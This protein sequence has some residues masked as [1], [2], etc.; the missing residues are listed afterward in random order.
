MVSAAHPAPVRVSTAQQSRVARAAPFLLGLIFALAALRSLPGGNIIDP[1]AARHA[2]NGAMVRDLV[3]SGQIMHPVAFGKR[4]YSHYP[5]L[6]IPY[7]PPLFPAI[8]SVF[9]AIGGV[10][11]TVARL[12]VALAVGISAVL[13][14]GLIVA[15]Y[16]SRA[17]AFFSTFAF[18]SWHWPQW[19]ANDVMLEF[20]ALALLL[21]SLYFIRSPVDGPHLYIFAV[22]AGAAVWTKQNTLFLGLVPFACVFLHR[23]WQVLRRKTIW[24]ASAVFGAAVAAFTGVV[25]MFGWT[26][27][28]Q[29]SSGRSISSILM[30]NPA[31]YAKSLSQDAGIVGTALIF[32]AVIAATIQA[33]RGHREDV[34]FLA[35]MYSGAAFL[36]SLGMLD[37]RYLIFAAPPLVVISFRSLQ[38][39]CER[40]AG[41]LVA[42][43]AVAAVTAVFSFVQ[44]GKPLPFLKGPAEAAGFVLANGP[45]RIVYCG[46]TGG[47]FTFAVR[48]RDPRQQSAVIRGDRLPHGMFD[49][50]AFENFAHRYG[51]RYVVLER[52]YRQR[53]WYRL[54]AH[55][56]PSMV[57]DRVIPLQASDPIWRGSLEV[58]RFTDPSPRPDD[59]IELHLSKVKGEWE[60]TF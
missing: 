10:H 40:F 42:W 18:L 12:A 35:W 17:L 27:L 54:S 15:H 2:M 28:A 6:S 52:T 43:I 47:Q 49:A 14:Y 19:V 41:P 24:L 44:F 22:I 7:H 3:A 13:L 9:Y 55:P 53:D 23:D 45:A 8:E 16:N 29:A 30:H 31:Y 50:A 59:T 5:A 38:R 33:L 4:Y 57:L 25:A 39:L 48:E 32:I 60:G 11:L 37:Q 46:G 1:D 36:L 26:G 51:V 21:A 58:Y 34:L 20:P 56:A